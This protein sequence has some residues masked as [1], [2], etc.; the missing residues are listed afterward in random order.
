MCGYKLSWK[1][2][3]NNR[4]ASHLWCWHPRLRIPGSAT[5]CH[6]AKAA[7]SIRPCTF[8]SVYAFMFLAPGSRPNCKK[9]EFQCDSGM[10]INGAWQCDGDIDCDDQSDERICREYPI[11]KERSH[12]TKFSPI[13]PTI[14]SVCYTV[15]L[16]D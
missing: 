5:A 15:H 6:A 9:G 11:L 10:C 7:S 2:G 1:I 14:I 8:L 4:L 12:V 16:S 13:F 3:Q